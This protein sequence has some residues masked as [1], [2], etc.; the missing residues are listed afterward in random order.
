MLLSVVDNPRA[1]VVLADEALSAMT[2]RQA[3]V[4]LASAL[5]CKHIVRAYA[6]AAIDPI[7]TAEATS[8]GKPRLFR[9]LVIRDIAA[10]IVK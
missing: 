9:R 10:N 3:S 1:A 2:A 4:R 6:T 5:N 8:T 7:Y